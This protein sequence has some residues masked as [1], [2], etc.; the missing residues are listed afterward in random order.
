MKNSEKSKL[1]QPAKVQ[2]TNARRTLNYSSEK[3]NR[4]SRRSYH[5]GVEELE[6]HIEHVAVLGSR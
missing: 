5:A 1:L 6:R 4:D 3:S 2:R